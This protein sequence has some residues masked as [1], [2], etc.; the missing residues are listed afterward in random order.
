MHIEGGGLGACLGLAKRAL[1]ERER[2]LSKVASA[3][4]RYGESSHSGCRKREFGDRSGL[5]RQ[6][7]RIASRPR[8]S[9]LPSVNGEQAG[10]VPKSFLQQN[11]ERPFQAGDDREAGRAEPDHW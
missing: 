7:M 3:S 10:V 1:N 11:I 8:I 5:S 6:D 4:G 9:V 2:Q